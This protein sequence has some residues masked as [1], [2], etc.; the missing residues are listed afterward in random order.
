MLCLKART[1]QIILICFSRR[2]NSGVCLYN[3]NVCSSRHTCTCTLHTTVVKLLIRCVERCIIER[4]KGL[5][6]FDVLL[7]QACQGN[8]GKRGCVRIS[9]FWL[10]FLHVCAVVQCSKHGAY[11]CMFVMPLGTGTDCP[12]LIAYLMGFYTHTHMA[13]CRV[14]ASI[15][16]LVDGGDG[17]GGREGGRE[18]GWE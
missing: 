1:D 18:G 7:F 2:L 13:S 5:S 3:L 6:T 11:L 16:V 4:Q 15:H 14:H 10:L 8:V 9:I 12:Q 17:R